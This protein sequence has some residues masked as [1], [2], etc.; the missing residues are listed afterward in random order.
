MKI[1]LVVWNVAL[2]T[3]DNKVLMTVNWFA[4]RDDGGAAIRGYL[5]RIVGPGTDRAVRLAADRER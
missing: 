5:V 1:G 4:P 2:V 3:A